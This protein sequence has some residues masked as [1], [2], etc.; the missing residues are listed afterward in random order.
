MLFPN[1]EAVHSHL[2]PSGDNNC[3]DVT[4][5]SNDDELFQISKLII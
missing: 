2:S 5:T 4:F 1:L 3:D